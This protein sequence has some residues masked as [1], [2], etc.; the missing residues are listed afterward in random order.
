MSI[1]KD[2]KAI[3]ISGIAGNE[4]IVTGEANTGML[5]IV[6]EL[7][8]RVPQGFN[9]AILLLDL[10]GAS[11]ASPEHFQPVQYNEKIG[12]LDQYSEVDIFHQGKVI[13]HLK[14]AIVPEKAKA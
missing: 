3:A 8:K 9:P 14:V 12:R 1:A 13:A 5:T 2:W 6:P 11:D 10:I 4:I 7:K